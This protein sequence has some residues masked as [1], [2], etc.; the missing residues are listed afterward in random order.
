MKRRLKQLLPIILPVFLL[1]SGCASPEKL[2]DSGNYDQAIEVAMRRLAGK[3]KLKEKYVQAL[4]EA[5]AKAN[6][7][8]LA[9]AARLKR[10]GRV[11]H[12]PDIYNHYRNIRLRQEKLAGLLPLADQY[13]VR[14][15]VQ[16]VKVEP[17]ER[18][19]REQAAAYYYDRALTLLAQARRGDRQA[20]RDAWTMLERTER[21]YRH[22]REKEQLQEEALALG[23]TFVLVDVENRAPVSIPNGFDEALLG[24]RE[25]DLNSKWRIFHTRPDERI[26][27][28]YRVTLELVNL[29]VSP[30]QVRERR[31]QEAREIEDGWDYVLDKN[32][33][34]AKDSLGNDLKEP[35]FV[36]IGVEVLENYQTKEARILGRM[37]FYDLT[38]DR[39]LDVREVQADALF[40]HYAATYRGDRRALSRE[41]RRLIGNQPRP[42]PTD[43]D[44]LLLAANR[45]KPAISQELRRSHIME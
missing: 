40:E 7:R 24:L 19:A 31:Y 41:S 30:E 23:T 18:E 38:S 8:D 42:F 29:A 25:G 34:V 1:L 26:S 36:K 39:I 37:S 44:M 20:A 10:D 43:A 14:A 5:F 35:R 4:E 16:F 17:L 12:W 27:Y 6:N 28:D 22:F 33:N 45:L 3:K 11:E 9:Y 13:G 32:G 15:Q 21:Y 2:V